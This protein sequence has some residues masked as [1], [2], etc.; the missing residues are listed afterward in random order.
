[1]KILILAAGIGSRLLP[2]TRNTPKSLIDL[3]NGMTL[4]ETQL[5]AIRRSGVTDLVILTG[6]R[7]EQIEAK[8][9]HYQDFDFE[10]VYNPFYDVSN[11]LVSAWMA[12]PH[13]SG[14]FILVNGD[15]VFHT[16]VLDRLLASEGEIVMVISRKESYDED[17]MKIETRGDRVYQ[18]SKQIEPGDANGE[19]IGMIRF[20]GMGRNWFFDELDRM[21]RDKDNLDEYYLRALQNLMDSGRP[22]KFVTCA[23]SEWAELDF[24]PDLVSLKRQLGVKIDAVSRQEPATEDGGAKE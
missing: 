4:L 10:I 12:M 17:D 9:R 14:D 13:I 8:I 23:P 18:V 3:G 1:M 20:K 16:E 24:H 19:S 5:D 21:V 15:D 22:V 6:Y 11:N 2:L 7:S